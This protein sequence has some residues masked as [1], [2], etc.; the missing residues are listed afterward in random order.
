MVAADAGKV[1]SVL[2]YNYGYGNHVIIDHGNG[3]TTLYAHLASFRVQ[4]GQTVVKGVPI[5]VM[6]STGRST[7]AHL[8]FEIRQNGKALSPLNYLK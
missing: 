1:I 3:F 4:Q 5:G 8:H 7:G 6:G 2:S